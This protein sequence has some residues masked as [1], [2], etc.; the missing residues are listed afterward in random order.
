ML[1]FDFLIGNT[2]RHQ[3]N[4]A[5]IQDDES[6][7]L[8]PLYDNGSSLCC[9]ISEEKIDFYLGNDIQRFQSLVNSKSTSRIRINK[10]ERKEPKHLEV[11]E[12]LRDNYY[13]E[14]IDIVKSILNN[15][16]EIS[17]NSI[18]EKYNNDILSMK[19][20]K[21]IKKFLVAKVE[22]LDKTFKM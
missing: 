2:D 14:V 6:N 18:L 8:S 15:I 4:W 9:Y 16:N 21:L 20:R 13:D 22:L 19:K 10:N 7:K 11:L 17:I 3:N 12:Y 5:I 1:I